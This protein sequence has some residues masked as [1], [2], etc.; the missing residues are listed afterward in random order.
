[1]SLVKPW[2]KKAATYSS[3]P[4]DEEKKSDTGVTEEGYLDKSFPPSSSLEPYFTKTQCLVAI[5][6]AGILSGAIGIAVGSFWTFSKTPPA[7]GTTTTLNE[8]PIFSSPES[9]K[10]WIFAELSSAEVRAVAAK[11]KTLLP[12]EI[13]TSLS[14]PYS[15]SASYITGTSAV[16]LI[17]PPKDEAL[18]FLEGETDAPPARYAKV[19]LARGITQDVMEYKIGPIKGC[20]AGDCGDDISVGNEITPLTEP[21]E[22]SWAK[23]PVDLGESWL[24]NI[25]METLK[26]LSGVLFER[27]GPVFDYGSDCKSCPDFDISQGSAFPFGFND[28]DSNSTNRVTKMMFFWYRDKEHGGYDDSLW[29]HP[30]PFS[31]HIDQ[32]NGGDEGSWTAYDIKLCM[33]GPYETPDDLLSAIEMDPSKFGCALA[34]VTN[35]GRRGSFDTPGAPFGALGRKTQ[36]G[37]MPA[38]MVSSPGSAQRW[39]S[40][41]GGASNAAGRMVEWQGWSFYTTVRPATGLAVLDVR[42]KGKR[43]AHEMAL[44]EA[45]AAY[46]G[47]VDDGDQV[48]YLDAAYSMSQMGG[49]LVPGVDCP[50]DAEYI[51][52]IATFHVVP[53]AQGDGLESDPSKAIGGA[54]AC[55]FE[56]DM[57]ETLWRHTTMNKKESDGVR[58]SNLVVRHVTT[59]GNYDYITEFKFGQDGSVKIGFNFAG[60]CETRWYDALTTPEEGPRAH[61]S[62]SEIVRKNLAAPLH[63][64]FGVFKLDL[65]VLGTDNTFEV[66]EAKSGVLSDVEGSSKYATKYLDTT[67]VSTEEEGV[68]TRIVDPMHPKLWRIVNRKAKAPGDGDVDSKSRPPGYAIV[69]GATVINTLPDDHPFVLSAAFSKYNLVV[70]KRHESEQRCTSVYDLFGPSEPTLSIRDLTDG[71][72]IE[73]TDLV[74]WVSLGKEHIPRTEDLPLISSSFGVEATLM[75]WNIFDGHAAMDIPTEETPSECSTSV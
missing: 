5:A 69:P 29:L 20:D 17:P 3:I 19:T 68:S 63:S 37:S 60:Y 28:I 2:W 74:A 43:I 51:E 55:I 67:Y 44:S 62:L 56:E 41:T 12:G 48:F 35:D 53:N 22:I 50:F 70:T 39:R 46:S 65:D 21:G 31:F 34:D 4:D 33:Q 64:H 30:L 18:A 23:R 32:K 59:V 16:E 47:S 38:R 66:I 52:D 49:P 36:E 24:N 75:P 27:F 13:F 1:M 57:A 61:G 54:T 40:S 73:D 14:G 6:L 10:H 9:S 15:A 26:P 7:C 45:M 58:N 71:E 42:F 72:N 11:A 8:A 25:V